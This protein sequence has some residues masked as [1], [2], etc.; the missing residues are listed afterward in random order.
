[1]VAREQYLNPPGIENPEGK[2]LTHRS[3]DNA[4]TIFQK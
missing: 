3:G 4:K 1:M 2:N